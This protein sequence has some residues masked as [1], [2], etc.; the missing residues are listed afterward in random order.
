MRS[1]QNKATSASFLES[2]SKSIQAGFNK[3]RGG[4]QQST[5]NNTNVNYAVQFANLNTW[6]P[7]KGYND[8]IRT[9]VVNNPLAAK[10]TKVFN[11]YGLYVGNSLDDL[12]SGVYIIKTLDENGVTTH[13]VKI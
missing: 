6:N 13:K 10:T 3:M 9:Y 8:L 11:M 5:P 1:N 7:S 2:A 12:S 4:S